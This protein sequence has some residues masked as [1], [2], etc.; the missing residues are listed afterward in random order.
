MNRTYVL[1]A[2]AAIA[3]VGVGVGLLSP[4]S[5][6]GRSPGVSRRTRRRSIR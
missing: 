5:R 2:I 6:T 4:A 3:I 1:I